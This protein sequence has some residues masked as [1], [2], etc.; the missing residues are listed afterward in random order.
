MNEIGDHVS[1]NEKDDG[2]LIKSTKILKMSK[3]GSLSIHDQVM[4]GYVQMKHT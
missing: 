3:K 1:F 4:E 2:G